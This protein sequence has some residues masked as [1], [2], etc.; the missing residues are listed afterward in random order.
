MKAVARVRRAAGEAFG[1]IGL[2][3]VTDL[4]TAG[5]LY[6]EFVSA[7]LDS[8][9][10]TSKTVAVCTQKKCEDGAEVK[11]E[12][13]FAVPDN[14]GHIGG[15]LVW[16]EKKCEIFLEK[17]V[18]CEGNGSDDCIVAVIEC[19]SW[20]QPKCVSPEKRI[21]FTTKSFLPSSTPAGLQRLRSADLEAKRGDGHGERKSFE[22]IYDYDKYNDLGDPDNIINDL[23]RPVLGGSKQFPYPRRCRTGRPSSQNDPHS[24]SRSINIYVPRD[25]A[26]SEIKTLTFSGTTLASALHAVSP[27]INATLIDINLGFQNFTA[28][29]ELYDQ[30]F[31]LPHQLEGQRSLLSRL[32]SSVKDA[33]DDL[34]L[35]EIPALIQNDKFSWLRDEEFARQTLAGVNPYA[36][37]LVKE[38]PILSKLDTIIYGHPESAITEQ[39]IE[40][41]IKGEMTARE[42][43]ERKR[44][45]MLDYHDL[46]LP[47]VH[48]V[49]EL[50]GTTLYGSRTVFFLKSDG[51][52]TPIAIELHCPPS[53]QSSQWKQVFTPSSDATT[54]WLW[55]F[56]KAHV[57]AH[58][59][60]HH[61]LISHWLRTHC[62]VEPYIIAGNRQLSTMHPIYKLLHPHFRYTMEING[63]AR[64]YLINAGGIIESSFSTLKYAIE[65]SSAAYHQQWR[66]DMEGL[67]ADLIKRGMAEEDPEAEHG[68]RLA[69]ADYPFAADGLLIWSAISN[70][71]SAYVN[72]YY[73]EPSMVAGDTELQAFW[74]EVVTRGHADKKDEPWWPKLTDARTLAGVLTT[75]IWVA[76]AHHAAVNFGQYHYGGYFPNRPTIARTPMPTEPDV[77]GG[78]GRLEEFL[79]KPEAALMECF[80]SQIQAALVMAVVDLLSSH[81][82]DEEY[83]GDAADAAWEEEAAVRAAFDRYKERLK[84]IEVIIDGRNGDMALRNRTGAGVLPYE[85][86]KPFSGPGVTGRGIPNSTSI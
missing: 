26:F 27:A 59:A 39:I 61:E 50:Q 81:S 55:R 82:P 84:E 67:P 21:F 79:K 43:A 72:H 22:I 17:I 53:T 71:V 37:E 7:E 74:A 11:Y 83:L 2:S 58:D 69:I 51:T 16:N 10:G 3:S 13:S 31:K 46:F 29:D 49:R 35:F 40:Q 23:A 5:N 60:G 48:K 6:L 4:L 15:V 73:P 76:S 36:I 63:L 44:L 1:C 8:P 24:E 34:L 52:L 70:W 14:F 85:F 77:S 20:V 25:E 18:V 38:L 80:P 75:I 68:L 12:G 9:S 33:A 64:Q 19:N 62:C 78:G 41:G 86:M 57:C 32:C 54:N 30:G 42:A 56:A 47:Y 45:F 65:L 66:F 28:I